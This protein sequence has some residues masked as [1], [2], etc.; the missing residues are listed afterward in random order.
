MRYAI[1]PAL[2]LAFK[3]LGR[4][5][6]LTQTAVASEANALYVTAARSRGVS[7]LDVTRKH[8]LPNAAIPVLTLLGDEVATLLNGA[9]VI[10]MIFGWP[11]VGNTL[12]QA[13]ER[14]DLPLIVACVAVVA[15]VVIIVNLIVDLAYVAVDPRVRR[16]LD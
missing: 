5:A 1:L 16:D 14:R 15:V 4:L 3:P 12:I 2:A 13:I 7:E 11:G 8:V 9:V 10:E 6:Q